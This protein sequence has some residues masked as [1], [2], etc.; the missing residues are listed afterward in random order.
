MG[1]K[2]KLACIYKLTNKVSGRVYIGET[3]NYKDRMS[4][5]KSTK[6]RAEAKT[7]TYPRPIDYAIL[8]F[9]FDSFDTEILFSD[10]ILDDHKTRLLVE[11]EYI[12]KY[13]ATNP[14]KG[15]NMASG[16]H[17]LFRKKPKI[18]KSSTRIKKSNPIISYEISTGEMFIWLGS[19]SFADE[20]GCDRSQVSRSLKNGKAIHGYYVFALDPALRDAN[21]YSIIHNK[22]HAKST[23]GKA[24]RTLVLY[25]KAYKE[26]TAFAK[27]W[28]C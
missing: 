6:Q 10:E 3:T 20:L 16:L 13:D 9:G 22:K 14:A 17:G 27:H 5:Y 18:S 8:D 1:R 11:A 12:K 15:Y 21:A 19:K 4:Y 24:E 23:N 26:V 2:N 7:L 25:E 28:G